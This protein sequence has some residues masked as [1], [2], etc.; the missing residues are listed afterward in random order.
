VRSRGRGPRMNGTSF[1]YA[2]ASSSPPSAGDE[3]EPAIDGPQ[4]LRIARDDD[5][6]VSARQKSDARIDHV[7]RP[8]LAADRTGGLCFLAIQRLHLD[9][10]GP[11]ESR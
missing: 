8:R 9:E 6:G 2:P 7:A 5:C 11:Q 10:T 3:I 4:I 1:V